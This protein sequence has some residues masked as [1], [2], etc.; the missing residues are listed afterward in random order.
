M[1][2]RYATNHANRIPPQQ[3]ST[4]TECTP[5]LWQRP[6]MVDSPI[7]ILN[8]RILFDV[9]DVS[10]VQATSLP[11]RSIALA[12]KSFRRKDQ[13]V[14]TGR[15]QCLQRPNGI[16]WETYSS[17]RIENYKRVKYLMTRSDVTMLNFADQ[18]TRKEVMWRRLG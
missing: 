2:T 6:Q 8:P 14:S 9:C 10:L 17:S 3:N 4:A 13:E 11:S 18:L 7:G 16:K 5:Q 15:Y 12:A 1:I